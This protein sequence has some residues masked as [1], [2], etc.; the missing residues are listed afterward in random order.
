MYDRILVPTDG[1]D[2][3]A[4]GAAHGCRLASAFGAAVHALGVVDVAAAGLFETDVEYAE[5][6]R[7]KAESGVDRVSELADSEGIVA[8]RTVTEGAPVATILEY[9]DR[10]DLIVMGTHG[11]TG[12]ERVALGSV[13]ERVLRR[14]PVPVVTARAAA[15]VPTDGY[16]SILVP[17]DGSETAEVAVEHAIE[18]AAAFDATLHAIH[19]VDMALLGGGGGGGAAPEAARSM[20]KRGRSQVAAIAQRARDRGLSA[21][22]TVETGFPA[23]DVLRYADREA[24]NLIVMGTTGRTGL[25]RIL[26]GSTTERVIRHATQPVMAVNARDD[27]E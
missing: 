16:R 18:V 5:S 25:N 9:A 2:S 14:A 7:S 17:T 3:A 11:R 27:G 13:T 20:E 21:T 24:I 8:E 22:T 12:I 1:S 10:A 23:G 26:L 19:V 4:A 6:L 15:T